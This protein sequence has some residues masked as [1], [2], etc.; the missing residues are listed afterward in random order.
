MVPSLSILKLIQESPADYHSQTG[1]LVVGDP[2]VGEV[3][4]RGRVNKRFVP[5]PGARKEAEM[6]GRLLGVKPLLGQHAT[7]QAVLEKLNSASESDAYC[8]TWQC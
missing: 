6:I 3:I 7:K 5:L 4:Y 2:D 1:A 8:C